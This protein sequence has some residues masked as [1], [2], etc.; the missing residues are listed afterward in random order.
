M[1]ALGESDAF[2]ASDLAL[3]RTM[4]MNSPRELE[5]VSQAWRP[6][7]AYAAMYLWSIF[8][9]KRTIDPVFARNTKLNA[10]GN[11]VRPAFMD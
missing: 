11:D 1:R 7:R 2:P 4:N 6:W 8:R 3:L 10:P 5:R 9:Q